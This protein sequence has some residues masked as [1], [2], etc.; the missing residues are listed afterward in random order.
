VTADPEGGSGPMA[1]QAPSDERSSFSLSYLAQRNIVASELE[2]CEARLA[3]MTAHRDATQVEYDEMRA[4]RDGFRTAL[5]AVGAERDTYREVAKSNK[6]HV[7][8]MAEEVERMRPVVVAVEAWFESIEKTVTPEE[9]V[10]ALAWSA[11]GHDL[12]DAARSA[13]APAH[14]AQ[15]GLETAGGTPSHSGPDDRA[16]RAA[17]YEDD[18]GDHARW[19]LL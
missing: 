13:T 1:M 14:P 11:Y 4:A 6:R 16:E 7:G 5:A 3:E 12:V 8:Y 18:E 15:G 17:Y 10:L 9:A 2:T 19:G